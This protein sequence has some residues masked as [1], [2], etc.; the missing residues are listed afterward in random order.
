MNAKK[1]KR[2]RRQAEKLT[3]GMA[4]WQLVPAAV[5]RRDGTL[6]SAAINRPNTTRGTYKRLKKEA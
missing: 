5:T 1:A 3:V 2:L 6:T 4:S